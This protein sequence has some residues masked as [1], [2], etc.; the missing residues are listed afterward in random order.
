MRAL[1]V[2]LAALP[3]L[4]GCGLTD[5]VAEQI[6]DPPA[7]TET[8][9][10]TTEPTASAASPGVARKPRLPA[11]ASPSSVTPAGQVY[12]ATA[13]GAA[14]F[15]TPSGNIVCI[16]A[17]ASE[18]LEAHTQCDIRERAYTAPQSPD[19]HADFYGNS[20]VL[21]P[22]GP[23]LACTSDI[24]T[25]YAELGSKAQ[26]LDWTAWF[27]GTGQRPVDLPGPPGLAATVGYG[28]SIRVGDVQ[29]SSEES[30]VRCTNR[31]S[32]RSFLLSRSRYAL[33]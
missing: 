30:G 14:A 8:V 9:T 33:D 19:C 10:V 26:G 11:S 21:G 24:I 18:M 20:I 17:A 15:A 27:H 22:S 2:T 5:V 16:I 6:A 31:A 23:E 25:T 12:D 28:N 32:N 13:H 29:C 4:S 7:A 1:V 3:L